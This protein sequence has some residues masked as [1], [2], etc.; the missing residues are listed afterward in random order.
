MLIL[1]PQVRRLQILRGHTLKLRIRKLHI[2][3]LHI[4]KLETLKQEIPKLRILRA[5]WGA[6][7]TCL[8][9]FLSNPKGLGTGWRVQPIVR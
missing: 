3:N 1:K 6:C 5:E 7:S 2:L 8:G 9:R 4:L